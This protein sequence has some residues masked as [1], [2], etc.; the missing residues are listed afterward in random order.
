MPGAQFEPADYNTK[1]QR[2]AIWPSPDMEHV[3]VTSV[4]IC[5]FRRN[6]IVFAKVIVRTDV[7]TDKQF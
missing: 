7:Q 4:N 3:W 6:R 5:E 1:W 2:T